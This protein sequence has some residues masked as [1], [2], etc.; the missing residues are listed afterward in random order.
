[1]LRSS[2]VLQEFLRS[3]GTFKIE[4]L[5]GSDNAFIASLPFL[6]VRVTPVKSPSRAGIEHSWSIVSINSLQSLSRLVASNYNKINYSSNSSSSNISSS[7]TICSSSSNSSSSNS[8]SSGGSSDTEI[9]IVAVIVEIGI[10]VVMVGVV[11]IVVIVG[12]GVGVVAVI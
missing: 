8:R 4:Y 2:I 7:S 10:V 3:T 11:V 1:M 6:L 9:G 12:V 5:S